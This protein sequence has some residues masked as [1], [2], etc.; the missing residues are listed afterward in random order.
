MTGKEPRSAG[1]PVL[2]RYFEAMRTHDW[3]DLAGCLAPDVHRT[4][5]YLDVVEG[6]QA[7]VD[8]L[9]RVL[10][11]LGNYELCVTRTRALDAGAALVEL[12]ETLDVDGVS[13]EFPEALVFTFDGEGRILTV[14]IYIKQPPRPHPP[15]G[16]APD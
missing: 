2:D 5:P 15:S 9:A 13:T 14:D 8:F 1:V 4:G 3:A 16:A 6:R 11:T 12:T 7:Y 10:P